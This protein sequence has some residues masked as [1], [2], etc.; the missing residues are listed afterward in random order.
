MKHQAKRNNLLILCSIRSSEKFDT[1]NTQNPRYI[2]IK[3]NLYKIV[4]LL[5]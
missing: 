5:N 3:T 4:K 1:Y 2:S